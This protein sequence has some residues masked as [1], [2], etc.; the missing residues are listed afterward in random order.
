[1]TAHSVVTARTVCPPDL[2]AKR[3]AS[4]IYRK[5]D[6]GTLEK[7]C[8]RCREYLPADNEF[9]YAARCTPDGLYRWCKACYL[10]WRATRETGKV[11]A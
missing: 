7:R 9:F 2:M 8:S 3:L 11:K 5:A 10:D 6:D 1:M 4:G